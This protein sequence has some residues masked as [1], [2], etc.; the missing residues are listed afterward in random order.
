[1]RI[2]TGEYKL[3]SHGA[4]LAKRSL[5]K[6]LL[7]GLQ[8]AKSSVE[9][10]IEALFLALDSARARET[11]FDSKVF[12]QATLYETLEAERGLP[13]S[14]SIEWAISAAFSARESTKGE[15]REMQALNA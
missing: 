1:M 2:V 7:P 4:L 12:T 10:K 11:A 9:T 13:S 14:G 8:A 15:M 3:N 6:I 5:A